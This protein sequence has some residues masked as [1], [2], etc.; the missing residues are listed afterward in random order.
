MVIRS[1]RVGD[2]LEGTSQC[3][4]LVGQQG[5]CLHGKERPEGYHCVGE[6]L[7][8]LPQGIGQPADGIVLSS[9]GLAENP[10]VAWSSSWTEGGGVRHIQS[11]A[12]Q[13]ASAEVFR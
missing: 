6:H 5:I 9:S 2:S 1:L 10:K 11:R 12:Q 13:E 4:P 7:K 3:H 8:F